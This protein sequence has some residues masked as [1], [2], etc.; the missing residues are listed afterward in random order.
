[1]YKPDSTRHPSGF[2]HTQ[3][4]Q[5]DAVA[6]I[7]RRAE[8]NISGQH[9]AA[10]Q[11]LLAEAWRLD[12]GN[13]YIP[14]IVERVQIMQ[15]M[16]HDI[17]ALRDHDSGRYLAVSVGKQFTGGIKPAAAQL[18]E[19]QQARLRRLLMVAVTLQE[20]GAYEAAYDTVLKAE[21]MSPVDG[22]VVALKERIRPQYEIAMARKNGEGSPSRRTDLPGVAASMAVKLL[23]D[24]IASVPPPAAPPTESEMRID[25]LRKQREQQR[26]LREQ[27]M[28]R[29]AGAN[30]TPPPGEETPRATRPAV[31]PPA[32]K[33]GLLSSLFKGKMF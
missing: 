32:G 12:P 15:S 11:E 22:E 29:Q 8:F 4:M 3:Q 13:P 33:S 27:Q 23:T 5:R 18:T 6:E 10:A 7:I 14:A 31:P 16:Q 19:D 17:R 24:D 9:Y 28:W 25:V 2:A 20:R 1:M 30:V 26:Q 21:E